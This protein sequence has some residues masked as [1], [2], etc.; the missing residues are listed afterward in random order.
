MESTKKIANLARDDSGSRG[1]AHRV[2]RHLA[3][4]VLVVW[5]AALRPRQIPAFSFRIVSPSAT[6]PALRGDMYEIHG[7]KD[8]RERGPV[9]RP[10][11]MMANSLLYKLVS[12]H[13]KVSEEL[14]QAGLHVQVPAKFASTM[15]V[16]VSQKS[17]QW[18]A[19]E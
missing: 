1:E 8:E 14:R 13:C 9:G 12:F 2:I 3:D 10:T 4:Y 6:A 19:D 16:N 5:R 17:R 11:P 15:V 7:K 18:L